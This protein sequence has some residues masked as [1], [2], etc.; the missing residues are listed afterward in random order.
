MADNV[1]LN[2]GVGG[3]TIASDEIAAAQYQRIKLTLGADGVNDGDVAAGNPMPVIE[4]RPSA[5]TLT[6]VA[7]SAS[8]VTLIASNASRRGAMVA[9]DSAAALYIKYGATAS[10]SSFTV[11]VAA[12][13]YFE[14]PQP[15]YTGVVDG[16]WD[17]ATGN[18]RVTEV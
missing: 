7:G 12:G 17:S 2:P 3:D 10:I 8:S 4:T 18:A 14:L 1:T 9:N 6:N 11:K 16:I 15:V 13:G 5:A